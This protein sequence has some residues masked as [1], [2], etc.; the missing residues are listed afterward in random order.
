MLTDFRTLGINDSLDKAIELTLAGSQK[1]FPV[2]DNGRVE[3]ILTQ[4]DLMKALSARDRYPTVS[5]AMQNNFMAIDSLEMMES[6][7]EK[8][9]E[10]NCHTL[11][12]TLNRR[13][14][15]LLTMDNLGEFLR[16]RTA[17]AG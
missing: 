15:G 1:D 10:C 6:A 12:V 2:V 9:K 16:I 7:F 13:L 3:G 5:S 8:L 14:V 17:M 11:P 4:D